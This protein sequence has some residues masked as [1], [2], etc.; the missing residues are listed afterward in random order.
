MRPTQ[1]NISRW[2][3]KLCQWLR[4]HLIKALAGTSLAIGGVILFFYALS[5]RELPEFTLI[6]LTGTLA[7]IFAIG[8]L[9]FVFIGFYCLLPGLAARLVLDSFYP[10]AKASPSDMAAHPSGTTTHPEWLRPFLP[11]A[12]L[13]ALQTLFILGFWLAKDTQ[14]A[15]PY[16]TT[17]HY[18][19]WVAWIAIVLLMLVDSQHPV[20]RF[21][22]QMLWVIWTGSIVMIAI[23]FAAASTDPD[24]LWLPLPLSTHQTAPA[25]GVDWASLTA[26]ALRNSVWISIITPFAFLLLTAIVKG[27]K[28]LA[29]WLL[30]SRNKSPSEATKTGK[31]GALCKRIAAK[32]CAT[33][34]FTFFLGLSLL[35]LLELVDIGSRKIWLLSLFT[36]LTLQVLLNWIAVTLRFWIQRVFLV[37][38]TAAAF[39][40]FFPVLANN[41]V[42]FPKLII[43]TLGLGNIHLPSISLAGGQCATL[44]P[45]G[46]PCSHDANPNLT[47]TNVNLLNKVGASTIL[48]LM[49]Q[50]ELPPSASNPPE[51]ASLSFA[52]HDTLTTLRTFVPDVLQAIKKS[53]CDAAL[54]EQSSDSQTPKPLLCIRLVVPKEQIIGYVKGGRRNYSAGYSAFLNATKPEPL[55]DR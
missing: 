9:F 20:A 5:I 7:A 8:L 37:L 16:D 35:V 32:L 53:D 31:C 34:A 4:N 50:P 10:E 21:L 11:Y 43:A 17:F 3:A 44:A 23:L 30:K 28:R 27:R 19:F 40:V 38:G 29:S 51:P 25:S 48:E 22:R 33:V 13:V 18:A 12:T 39:L 54:L 2:T 36:L 47:L 55:P 15:P 46:V 1:K 26:A 42:Y 45:Y 41:P 52:D 49:V 24:Q 6:D 14:F